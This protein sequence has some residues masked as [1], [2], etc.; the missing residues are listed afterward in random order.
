MCVCVFVFPHTYL[1]VNELVA[2]QVDLGYQIENANTYLLWGGHLKISVIAFK[3]AQYYFY[4][5]PPFLFLLSITLQRSCG[6]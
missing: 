1:S 6:K 5:L 4:K 2:C 3:Y